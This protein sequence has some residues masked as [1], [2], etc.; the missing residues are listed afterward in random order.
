MHRWDIGKCTSIST[1]SKIC[2]EWDENAK[3]ILK[4]ALLALLRASWITFTIQMKEQN[5]LYASA[6]DPLLF[7]VYRVVFWFIHCCDY[8]NLR[9]KELNVDKW[10]VHFFHSHLDNA[11]QNTTNNWIYTIRISFILLFKLEQINMKLDQTTGFLKRVASS[12]ARDSGSVEAIVA[13]EKNIKESWKRE[14]QSDVQCK[15][16]KNTKV[17]NPT[18]SVY[19]PLTAFI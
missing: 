8:L 1:Y 9:I 14:E 7:F 18:N 2:S 15:N 12:R 4:K 17:F 5:F 3:V 13:K 6:I 11:V 16:D 19:S 10:R